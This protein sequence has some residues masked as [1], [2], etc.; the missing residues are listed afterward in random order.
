MPNG[1]ETYV[2]ERGVM[3]SGR[4]KQQDQYCPGVSQKPTHCHFR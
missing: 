3:L 4:Q 1:Y 2:G